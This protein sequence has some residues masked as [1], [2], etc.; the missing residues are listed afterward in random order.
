MTPAVKVAEWTEN[1]LEQGRIM[2]RMLEIGVELHLSKAP[3]VIAAADE[4]GVVM[5]FT[6]VRHFR[7]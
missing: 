7:H 2:R 4:R 1:T 3:E 6:G 5:V